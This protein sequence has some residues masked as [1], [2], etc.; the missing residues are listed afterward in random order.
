MPPGQGEIMDISFGAESSSSD[1]LTIVSSKLSKSAQQAIQSQQ[2]SQIASG[3]V[4]STSQE[5]RRT[6]AHDTV[7]PEERQNFSRELLNLLTSTITHTSAQL[8]FKSWPNFTDEAQDYFIT[9]T[10]RYIYKFANLIGFLGA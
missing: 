9:K 3:T 7:T 1:D 8:L 10:A 6:Q 2:A 5:V 4:A